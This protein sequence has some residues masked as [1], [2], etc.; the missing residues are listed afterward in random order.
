[1]C[2]SFSFFFKFQVAFADAFWAGI[3]ALSYETITGNCLIVFL[4]YSIF[5]DGGVV[6][7]GELV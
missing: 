2:M 6:D 1:M 7:D 3:V 5:G 4:E